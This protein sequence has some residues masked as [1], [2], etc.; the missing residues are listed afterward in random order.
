M[1]LGD[2]G[3]VLLQVL[4]K[5]F[6]RFDA[7]GSGHISTTELSQ[8]LRIL[9]PSLTEK[10]FWV[11]FNEFDTNDDGKIEFD[12]FVDFLAKNPAYNLESSKTIE[13][14]ALPRSFVNTG[15]PVRDVWLEGIDAP[16]EKDD[17]VEVYT[18]VYAVFQEKTQ[19]P[20]RKCAGALQLLGFSSPCADLVAAATQFVEDTYATNTVYFS[21]AV[22]KMFCSH[23]NSAWEALLKSK[24]QAALVEKEAAQKTGLKALK[25]RMHDNMGGASLQDEYLTPSFRGIP[26][27]DLV[28]LLGDVGVYTRVDSLN[29]ILRERGEDLDFVSETALYEVTALIHRRHGLKKQEIARYLGVWRLLS[30]NVTAIE[31]IKTLIRWL[32]FSIKEDEVENIMTTIGFDKHIPFDSFHEC[33]ALGLMRIFLDRERTDVLGFVSSGGGESGVQR[34]ELEEVLHSLNYPLTPPTID[35]FLRNMLDHSYCKK[36]ASLTLDEFWIFFCQ[37]RLCEGFTTYEIDGFCEAYDHFANR[38]TGKLHVRGLDRALR[39]L[40]LAPGVINPKLMQELMA[41]VDLDGTGQLD[42]FEF[43]RMLQCAFTIEM[44]NIERIFRFGSQGKKA[45]QGFCGG[46]VGVRYPPEGT[47]SSDMKDIPKLLAAMGRAAGE[48]RV[49][50]ALD[51]ITPKKPEV[52]DYFEFVELMDTYRTQASDD[53]RNRGLFTEEEG[54]LLR[55]RFDSLDTNADGLIKGREVQNM[56]LELFPK[57][58]EDKEKFARISLILEQVD[59]NINYDVSGGYGRALDFGEFLW[60]TQLS[61]EEKDCNK[62]IKEEALASEC[63]YSQAEVEEFRKLFGEAVGHGINS[64][65]NLNQL[66]ALLK[67]FVFLNEEHEHKLAQILLKVDADSNST[68]DFPEFLCVMRQLQD[69]NFADINNEADRLD[70]LAIKEE[71]AIA[72]TQYT[73]TQVTEMRQIYESLGPGKDGLSEAQV[74]AMLAKHVAMTPAVAKQ[75]SDLMVEV[76]ENND[77]RVDFPE[78][79]LLIKRLQEWNPAEVNICA[80]WNSSKQ[81]LTDL[82]TKVLVPGAGPRVGKRGRKCRRAKRG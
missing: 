29:E 78:F 11:L 9:D 1:V 45:R 68:M 33:L 67:R 48:D 61:Q 47:I 77:Q 37:V 30:K 63:K 26:V 13:H 3:P 12:E 27:T 56:L 76:A 8:I 28:S 35:S 44:Q 22:F 34:R 72:E 14:P 60:L 55:K 54:R 10:D 5:E 6:R 15:K 57:M 80:M 17:P 46:E 53:I 42:L 25:S 73:P 43:M 18:R 41:M 36:D 64:E 82:S 21:L 40:G 65:M 66:K 32:N 71:E 39:W 23:Y 19:F 38:S 2:T 79:L 75:L 52:L 31:A 62:Q 49:K 59:T 50:R 58:Q 20:R 24:L 70:E 81:E 4:K 16:F 7:D 69:E 74:Q 51:K